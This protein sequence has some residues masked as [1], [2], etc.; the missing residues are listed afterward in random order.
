MA[1]YWKFISEPGG[2]PVHWWWVQ[3]EDR[4]VVVHSARRFDTFPKCMMDASSH[5]FMA[6]QS[7]EVLKDRRKLPRLAA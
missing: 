3:C 5:G 6:S 1:C 2:E 4:K 7:F